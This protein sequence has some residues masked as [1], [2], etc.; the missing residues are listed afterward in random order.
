MILKLTILVKL[1]SFRET[2]KTCCSKLTECLF[3]AKD[4]FCDLISNWCINPHGRFKICWDFLSMIFIFY[5]LVNVPFVI[6]FDVPSNPTIFIFDALKDVFFM[7]DVCLNFKTGYI[8]DGYLI[9]DSTLIRKRYLKSWFL[10]DLLTSLP[11]SLFVDLAF[12][13]EFEGSSVRAF[14]L[15]KFL[16]FVRLARVFKAIRLKKLFVRMEEFVYS[17][18]FNG[19]KGLIGLFFMIILVAHWV[20]CIWHFVGSVVQDSTGDSWM[21]HYDIAEADDS[22]RYIASMYW[23]IAT[24][25]TVGYGDILPVS[26]AERALNIV[27]MLIGCAVFA[28]SMNSIGI[29]VQ[30]IQAGVSRTRLMYYNLSKYMDQKRVSKNIRSKVIHYLDYMIET[31][32]HGKMVEDQLFSILSDN[33]RAEL[34]KDINGQVL[35]ENALLQKNFGNKFLSIL[36]NSLEEKIFSPGEV[37]FDVKISVTLF[38]L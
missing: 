22:D 19:I 13:N 1:N 20:A 21:I 35:R 2:T 12:D 38:Y 11:I 26:T 8:D 16:R 30:N 33:I 15:L 18:I 31:Q 17:S 4:D 37:I 14:R 24:M 23:A 25:L 3:H 28:Y 5:D 10:V 7:I 27:V 9:T 29:L 36:S 6:C 32:K 34:K